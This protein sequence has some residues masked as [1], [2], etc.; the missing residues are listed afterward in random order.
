LD[1]SSC[2]G[3][4]QVE[5]EGQWGSVCSHSWDLR[6]AEVVCKQLGC[7]AAM[8]APHLAHPQTAPEDRVLNKVGCLGNETELGECRAGRLGS[9]DCQHPWDAGV[10]CADEKK[11]YLTTVANSCA[12]R[13]D[14]FYRGLQGTIC[15]DGWGLNESHVA[16]RQ[17]GCGEA[18]TYGRMRIPTTDVPIWL[19]RVHCSGNESSLWECS[20][21]PWGH[22]ECDY[23]MNVH[24]VCKGALNFSLQNGNSPCAGRLEL[25]G[26]LGILS[27]PDE[28]MDTNVAHVLCKELRC[29]SSASVNKQAHYGEVASGLWYFPIRCNGNESSFWHCHALF[30]PRQATLDKSSYAGLVCFDHREPRIVGGEDPCSGRVEVQFG[31]EWGTLC[32]SGWDLQDASV[33]CRQLQCGEAVAIPGGARYGEGKGPVWDKQLD[34]QGNES[35]VFECPVSTEKTQ[36]CSH[37]NYAS[38][39]CSGQEGPMLVGGESRCAG[40]VEVLHGSQWG[41]LC[42]RDLEWQTAEV[43]CR[44]LQCGGVKATPRGAPYGVGSVP[45]WKDRYQCSGREGRLGDCPVSWGKEECEQVSV[46]SVV[47]SDEDWLVRLQGTHSRCEGRVEILMSGLWGRVLDSDWD[48]QDANSV[49]RSLS[50]GGALMAYISTMYGDGNGPVLLTEVDCKGNESVL[51]NCSFTLSSGSV[52]T[53]GGV[54]VLCSGIFPGDLVQLAVVDAEPPR[55]VFFFDQYGWRRP[56]ARGG[57]NH[58][59]CG[60][61]PDLFLGGGPLG[62]NH[63][64]RWDAD[65]PSVAG[66]DLVL[67]QGSGAAGQRCWQS[68]GR[69]SGS[70]RPTPESCAA[71][72]RCV[73]SASPSL[74]RPYLEHWQVRLAGVGSL[75]AGRVEVY[76]HGA[77][78]SVC[79]DFWDLVDASVVCRQLGCGHALRAA[80]SAEFGEGSGPVWMDDVKCEGNESA[81]WNCPRESLEK[82]NCRHKE[83]A[84]VVCSEHKQLRLVSAEYNCA[85]RLEV[86]YNGTWG[87]VCSNGMDSFTVDLICK[88]LQCGDSGTLQDGQQYESGSG[89]KWLDNMKCLGQESVL[90]QCSSSPWGQNE[91]QDSEEAEI[92][93]SAMQYI[94]FLFLYFTGYRKK[95]ETITNDPEDNVCTGPLVRL[96]GA[97]GSCSGRVEVC[98]RGAWGT[99]CDDSWDIQEAHVICR[100][101]GCGVGLSALQEAH[102]GEGNGTVWLDEVNCRG[103]ERSLLECCS[104]P[105]GIHDCTHKEDAAVI[106]SGTDWSFYCHSPN[107]ECYCSTHVIVVIRMTTTQA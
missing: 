37:R 16:C 98:Q 95:P 88:Q 99:V 2:S 90:W 6:D 45:L 42:E 20:S 27:F 69:T 58:P 8:S 25:K 13:V 5:S 103:T 33:V 17:A 106:C 70:T 65:G 60:H 14:V 83:D 64:S 34:C 52:N 9:K 32:D 85:G 46:A 104:S 48:L 51:Q 29:G 1:G 91:C 80:V 61:L 39:V 93:C 67:D 7:G 73:E 79:D 77:W 18:H 44:H 55:A 22:H 56:R 59:R 68:P 94:G 10:I 74:R 105:P 35:I 41:S 72:R 57:L 53:S 89:P 3:R 71:P 96:V 19:D 78:G 4:V 38:V 101:L 26:E 47:C 43:I 54:G 30:V 31:N 107:Y 15:E 92:Q 62:M 11:I 87:S 76:H 21:D 100:E 49:C 36:N 86:L 40:R 97:E 50:C 75:C 24:V 12:G 84:G 66:V 63:A 82:G 28:Y 102:F 23:N 81:L